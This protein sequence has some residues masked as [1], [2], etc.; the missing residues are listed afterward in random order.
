MKIRPAWLKPF[1]LTVV[2]ACAPAYAA[3][4]TA[5]LVLRHGKVVTV[6][7]KQPQ[8]QA[9]AVAGNHI[10]AVGSDAAVD[11]L[12]G[13]HTQVVDLK[14]R[15]AVPGFI[16][17]HGHFM[18]LGRAKMELD[19][20]K[21]HT[22]SD[23][24]TM[25]AAAARHAKPGAWIVGHGWHQEK[26][27]HP[28][29]PNIDGLPL[30]D[31]LDAA[32]P[33]NPVLLIHA[34]GH[35]LF[36]NA[37]ALALAGIGKNTPDPK[38]GQIV[39]KPDGTPIG[40]LRDNAQGLVYAVYRKWLAQR[41]P[42]EVEA[43]ALKA[44]QLA[45]ADALSKGITSFEDEGETFKT[46]DF[47]K[48]LA[49]DGKLPLRLYAMINNEPNAALAKH[50]ADYRMIDYGKHGFLTVRAVGEI[51]ADGALGTHSAWFLKPYDDLPSSTGIDVTPIARIHQ[52]AEIALRNH[53]QLA[54][55]AIGDR[56]NREVL[57]VY[58]QVF[59]AHPDAR[60]LRWR[61][62]HAQHLNPADIPRFAKLHVI[63]SM[64]A[65]HACSDGPYVVK[66]I[67]ERRAKE[68]AYAW[69]SLMKTGAI[70]T[71]GTDVPVE[72]ENPIPNFKCAVTRQLKDGSHFFPAQVMTRAEALKA[73]TYWN[74]YD[75]F[76]EKNLGSLT[77][78]KLADIVVLSKDIMKIPADE[79]DSA[80]VDYTILN[81]K[82]V[83]RRGEH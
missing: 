81:G 72:D 19:L 13:P 26:W 71:N 24:V 63:A 49:S 64:Q 57:D 4:H 82:I 40:M 33:H 54:V 58:E 12:I 35:A 50:L 47:Y 56:A 5:D 76:Q 80:R 2:L 43:D 9:I 68:G 78:G 17:G 62:E 79:I 66:R 18:E 61:I 34:S 75:M 39:R 83:Y 30:G 77:P 52:I 11:K 15:L 67:G 25:V 21:A 41:T 23:I 8:A 73:Y 53:F 55:H 45:G 10:L 70:V 74:A 48:R 29:E 38:G 22:W 28:P 46:I 51:H 14:G 69:R 59:R 6:D 36:V 20:T 60:N 1:P 37:K 27:T 32:S 3:S 44:V 7:A 31:K 65:I 42:T 16:E